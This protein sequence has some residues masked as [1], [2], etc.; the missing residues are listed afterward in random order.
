MFNGTTW[1]S[2]TNM[3]NA[4]GGTAVSL[5]CQSTKLCLA[6]DG[7]GRVLTFNGTNWS[8]PAA[9]PGPVR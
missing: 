8:T 2:P 3:G 7:A 9:V 6:I 4:A 5:S 1:S